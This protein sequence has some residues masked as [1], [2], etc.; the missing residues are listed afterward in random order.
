MARYT[1]LTPI[2]ANNRYIDVG[3]TVGDEGNPADIPIPSNFVCPGLDP[4]NA[5]AISKLTAAASQWQSGSLTPS[6]APLGLW[7][8]RTQFV[9]LPVPTPSSTWAGIVNAYR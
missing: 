8:L 1:V 9:L 7:N 5:D 4:L 6:T 3:S 2:Y